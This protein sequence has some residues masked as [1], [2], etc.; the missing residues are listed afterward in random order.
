[1]RWYDYEKTAIENVASGT[2]TYVECT[3]SLR[4]VLA[5]LE[6]V[7]RGEMMAL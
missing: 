3:T 6:D 2:I 4:H 5:I 1:M 7:V